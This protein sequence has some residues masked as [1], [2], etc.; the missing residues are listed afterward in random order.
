M[1]ERKILTDVFVEL[2]ESE[3][4]IIENLISRKKDEVNQILDRQK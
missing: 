2:F 3:D 1:L 4:T